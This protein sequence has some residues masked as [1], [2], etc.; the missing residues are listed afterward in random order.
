MKYCMVEWTQEIIRKDNLYWPTF[1]SF[2]GWICQALNLYVNNK[3]PINQEES[4]YAALWVGSGPQHI[5][6]LKTKEKKK[7]GAWDP[8][9]NLP[10]PY[11]AQPTAPTLPLQ[12]QPPTPPVT[13]PPPLQSQPPTDLPGPTTSLLAPDSLPAHRTRWREKGRNRR[14]D[15]S[16]EEDEERGG[17]YPL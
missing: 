1:G 15:D 9:E 10:P 11:L 14:R 6:T 2:E 4:D 7:K 13:S 8:L 12:P 17:L 16:E 5:Y 3:E